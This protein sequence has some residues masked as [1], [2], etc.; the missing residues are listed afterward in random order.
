[1]LDYFVDQDYFLERAPYRLDVWSYWYAYCDPWY[2]SD[3][4]SVYWAYLSSCYYYYYFDWA[5]YQDFSVFSQEAI[6]YWA[7]DQDAINGL[8]DEDRALDEV[9]QAVDDLLA[10]PVGGWPMEEILGPVGE[11][12]DPFVRRGIEI[13]QSILG[14]LRIGRNASTSELMPPQITRVPDQIYITGHPLAFARSRG[15]LALEYADSLTG[16]APYTAT[17]ISSEPEHNSILDFGK[18]IAKDNRPTDNP[19][20]NFY[21]GDVDPL[22]TSNRNYWTGYLE[23]RHAHYKALPYSELPKYALV[24]NAEWGTNNSNSYISGITYDS[25]GNVTVSVP[26]A[27]RSR[28]PGWSEPVPDAKFR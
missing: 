13:A 2:F 8:I 27:I 3:V 9:E 1:M 19:L 24:P 10:T 21:V 16:G 14:Q 20:L 22:L 18:L 6:L 25:P 4:D 12:R 5:V 15:H 23:T 11:H 28:Y 7:N 17:T 26:A